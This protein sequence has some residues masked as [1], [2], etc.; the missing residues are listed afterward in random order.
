ML[1]ALFHYNM[2]AADIM[3]FLG[4]T[5]TGEHSGID[6]IVVNLNSHDIDPWLISQYIYHSLS[7]KVSRHGDHGRGPG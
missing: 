7:V 4:G 3:R 2:H 1:A 6:A 5:Y